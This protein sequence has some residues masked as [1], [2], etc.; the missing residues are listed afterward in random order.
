MYSGGVP[1]V[2]TVGNGDVNTVGGVEY[3]NVPLKT[4]TQYTI[5]TRYDLM[6]DDGSGVRLNALSSMAVWWW[7]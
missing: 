7:G 6:N 4:G 2:V 5:F 1:S 3:D